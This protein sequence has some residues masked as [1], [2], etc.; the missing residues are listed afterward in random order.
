MKIEDT[1]AHRCLRRWFVRRLWA[2]RLAL[3]NVE[4]ETMIAM[5]QKGYWA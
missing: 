1:L 2:L 4:I 3:G 5:I